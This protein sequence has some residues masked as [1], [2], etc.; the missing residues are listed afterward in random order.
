MNNQLK[1]VQ[2]YHG[3]IYTFEEND[4]SFKA[5]YI[6]TT[7]L[8]DIILVV[9]FKENDH[10]STVINLQTFSD[11]AYV[12]EAREISLSF[13]KKPLYIKGK[14][15]K[16]IYYDYICISEIILSKYINKTLNTYSMLSNSRKSLL[17]QEDYILTEDFFK[18]ITWFDFK[19]KLQFQTQIKRQP[20]IMVGGVYFSELGQNI[21]TE[22]CKLRPVIIYRKCV[23]QNPNDSSYI[24]IPL[25][26][27]N[28]QRGAHSFIINGVTN[29][30]CI[31]DMRRVSLKRIKY[32]I[33]D[34]QRRKPFFVSKEDFRIIKEDIKKYFYDT[35]KFDTD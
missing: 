35:I 7:N 18:F 25:S 12:D 20:G 34:N 21:G 10:T 32:P 14:P 2:L 5:I 17:M 8:K 15:A 33:I 19:T 4:I 9:P 27:R 28:K 3:N 13:L 30:V 1:P 31:N 24:V 11:V 26:S 22:L 29:Y 16:I 6:C 23:A